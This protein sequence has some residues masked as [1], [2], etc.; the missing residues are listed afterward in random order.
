MIIVIR[1]VVIDLIIDFRI[2]FIFL[3]VIVLIL[4]MINNWTLL[5]Y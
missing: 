3:I 2:S 4:P 5:Q 1:L